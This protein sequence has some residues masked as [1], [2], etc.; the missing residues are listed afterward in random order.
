MVEP[1]RHLNTVGSGSYAPEDVHFLLQPVQMQVT[2]VV[3]KERL[4]Q[5]R[6]KHYSEMISLESAPTAVHQALYERALAQNGTRMATDVQ[7]LA[8]AL[9]EACAGACIVLVSFVRAGLPLGVLLRRALIDMGRNTYH[10][11]ISIVRDRG[12]DTVALEA[13]IQAHGAENI[14]FVDGWTGKGAISA[15]I[16]RSLNGDSR[17][18]TD[19]R[20]VVLAD[21]CGRA[22]LSASAEDWVIPSG[23][24]GATVSGLVSRSIW[25]VDGGLHG[26]VVYDHLRE[27]DVT[28]DFIEQIETKRRAS[29]A[30]AQAS[31]WTVSQRLELQAAASAVVE[32]L[33]RRFDISNPNRVKPGI[34]EA[35]RAVLRRVPDR[36]LVRDRRDSDVQLLLH[37]TEG[38][39][40]TVEEAGADLGPYR[41]V[42][43]IRSLS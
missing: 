22:W 32:S 38:A 25:P 13:I 36:V 30:V 9:N 37:L 26:C 2:D 8:L 24:L 5:T 16:K 3:E 41:A 10:Y 19:P 18:P 20:L 12:I 33:A 43:I 21:P 27:H 6:Q 39:G 11:G 1:V 40:V 28:R 35:T 17:F 29:G 14:V 15:E 34:A 23:I 31:P 4:I 42:T 7:S